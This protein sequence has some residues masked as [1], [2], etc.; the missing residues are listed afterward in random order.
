MCSFA[1]LL[2]LFGQPAYCIPQD[3]GKLLV[4]FN[5]LRRAITIASLL[6]D[7]L[8]RERIRRNRSHQAFDILEEVP[9]ED[10]VLETV[11]EPAHQARLVVIANRLPVTCSKDASGKWHLQVSPSCLYPA[12][13]ACTLWPPR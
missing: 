7:R 3:Y 4:K 8:L 13:H 9:I 6:P 10:P 5:D 1:L 2:W 12:L 11:P